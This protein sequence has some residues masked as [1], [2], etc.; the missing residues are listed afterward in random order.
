MKRRV[1]VYACLLLA[2]G[3]EKRFSIGELRPLA[4]DEDGG[5]GT[6]VGDSIGDDDAGAGLCARKGALFDV[7]DGPGVLC[8]DGARQAFRNAICSCGDIQN[9][10]PI[11]VDAFDSTVGAYVAGD[12]GGSIGANG[13]FYPGPVNVGRS[14]WVAGVN[15]IPLTANVTV[16]AN[17]LDQGQ[18]DGPYAVSIGGAA[19]IAGGV[20]VQKL[21]AKSLVVSD[22]SNVQVVEGAPPFERAAVQVPAPCDCENPLD[23]AKLV[24]EHSTDNDNARIGLDAK[25]SFRSVNGAVE[26]TLPC[27]RYYADAFYAPN[28]ITL[29]IS[30]TVELYIRGSMVADHAGTIDI[31]FAPGGEIDLFVEK[32]FSVT[33]ELRIGWP[34]APQRARVYAGGGQTLFFSGETTIGGS[35]YAPK[36]ELVASAPF[37]VFGAMLV[38]RIASAGPLTVHYDRALARDDCQPATCKAD[39]SCGVLACKGGECAACTTAA[40]CGGLLH[41][42]HGLCLP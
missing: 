1:A 18:L 17:L 22:S 28:P 30:G 36:G 25:E 19:H 27:G 31:Q 5:Q 13:S 37:N 32:G 11:V 7:G 8:E 26:L 39:D 35:M 42:D 10:G 12:P 24:A 41:C 23:I 21:E 15:G 6:H 3:C 9:S 33:N 40:D 29:T 38:G 4:I 20:N 2:V 34:N 16:G 14:L